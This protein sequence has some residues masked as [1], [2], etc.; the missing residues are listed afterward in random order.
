MWF[1]FSEGLRVVKFT[2]TERRMVVAR[3]K[4]GQGRWE[5]V[6]CIW[7]FSLQAVSTHLVVLA[8]IIGED[9]GS[10]PFCRSI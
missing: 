2:E 10:R 1:H 9:K 6:E 7:S 8:K 3:G 4:Q 5:V